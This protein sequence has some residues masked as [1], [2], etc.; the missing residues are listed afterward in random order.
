M[1]FGPEIKALRE[2]LRLT[3]AA[4]AGILDVSKSTL[5]KWEAGKKTPATITQEGAFARLSKYQPA[6]KKP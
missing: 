4:T 5:E 2:R 1:S 6:T 3:Q